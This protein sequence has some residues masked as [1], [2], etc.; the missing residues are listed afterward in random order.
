MSFKS[1]S[2]PE[3]WR[4]V[5]ACAGVMLLA[6]L[7]LRRLVSLPIS[8]WVFALGLLVLACLPVL[9]YLGYRTWSTLSLEYWVDRDAVTIAWG[10]LREVIPL[11]A[12]QHMQRGGFANVRGRW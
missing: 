7:L 1:A 10:P 11:G 6:A 5:L 9:I 8:G 4:G 12:I 3:A 2:T